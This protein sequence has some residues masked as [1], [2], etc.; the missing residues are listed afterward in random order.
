MPKKKR[1]LVI[2]AKPRPFDEEAWKRFIMAYAYY[3]HDEKLKA[4]RP[5]RELDDDSKPGDEQC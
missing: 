3:L 1:K 4:E 5:P 2:I